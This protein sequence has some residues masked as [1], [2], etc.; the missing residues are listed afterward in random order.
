M[1]LARVELGAGGGALLGNLDTALRQATGL[2][3]SSAEDPLACVVLGTGLCLENMKVLKSV[4][5]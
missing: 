2:P 3:V 1:V 5:I 4:L